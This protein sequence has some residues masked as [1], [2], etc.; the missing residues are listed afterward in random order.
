MLVA[1]GVVL[2]AALIATLGCGEQRRSQTPSLGLTPENYSFSKLAPG[3]EER[4]VVEIYNRGSGQLVLRGGLLDDRSTAA[5]F[6][7][8]VEETDGA[9][10]APAWPEVIAGGSETPLRLV[11]TYRPTD[12]DPRSDVG[13]VLLES[14]DP[15]AL[16]VTL[17]ILTN[18]SGP[19]IQVN[20][21]SIDFGGVD[22]GDRREEALT[23]TNTG[24]SALVVSG[25]TV[26]GSPDFTV[27][28][29]DRVLGA[30]LGD[31]PVVVEPGGTTALEV[32][33]APGQPGPDEGALVIASNDAAS[34]EIVVNLS[35]NG[36]AP[37]IEVTPADSLDFGSALKVASVDPSTPTPNVRAIEIASCGGSELKILGI[38][39][40]GGDD[41]FRIADVL[42]PGC[43]DGEAAPD[44]TGPLFS[45]PALTPDAA[46]PSRTL[47]MEFR[48]TETRAYGG[49]LRIRTNANPPDYLLDLFGRGV[50]N[51]CPIPVASVTQLN[52]QPLDIIDLDGSPSTDPEGQ[53]LEWQ[54][55]VVSRP[56][57]SRAELVE[58]FTDPVVPVDGG[59]PDDVSTPQAKF[60]IDL[61]G[62]YEF[63]LVVRDNLGQ[64]S[65]DPVASARVTVD[66]IPEKDLHVQLVWTTPED[67]D[68]TDDKGTDVDLHVRHSLAG[69]G[70]NNAA[71]GYDCYYF[72]KEP[73][74]GRPGDPLDNPSLDIDDTNG[75]GPE[76]VNLGQ[77]ETGV[78]YDVAAL[79]FRAESAFGAAGADPTIEHAVLVTVRVYVRGELLAEW[80]DRTLERRAQLWWVASVEWCEDF[81]QC[82]RLT[83]RDEVLEEEDYVIE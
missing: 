49:R 56:D 25:F 51:S 19:E 60:F 52:V 44:C 35:A 61:A 66:A 14:N 82:P 69:E 58:S 13:E 76:N 26:N 53:V 38:T 34:P 23:I 8:Q 27:E 12:E 21:T 4:D 70:W 32:V 45:L 68:E 11:V 65:C 57:G 59:P 48:P 64:A 55:T 1:R 22:F 50:D 62:H 33:Y 16:N 15:D 24:V 43:E 63:D 18:G 37:C 74:W 9:L 67:P 5:E 20:P 29:G 7:L 54:W 36:A 73:D 41:T 46:P 10:R 47:Q 40:E 81:A 30:D 75:G 72:N 28:L 79:Y 6:T 2:S 3:Q 77:P 78:T 83:T 39:V 80:L 31:M 71:N 42:E 17:P